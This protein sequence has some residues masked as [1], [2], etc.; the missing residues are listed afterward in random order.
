MKSRDMGYFSSYVFFRAVNGLVVPC[1]LRRI[2]ARTNIHRCF[3][4]G[5]LYCWGCLW[6]WHGEPDVDF[7]D[8]YEESGETP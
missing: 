8:G 4:L 5:R 1:F 7:Y 3:M 2:F 6:R